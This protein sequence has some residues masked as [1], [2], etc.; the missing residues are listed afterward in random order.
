MKEK[1]TVV[2]WALRLST[3]FCLL[4]V[5]YYAPRIIN[6]LETSIV[7]DAAIKILKDDLDEVQA[8]GSI[9]MRIKVSKIEGDINGLKS[10]ITDIRSAQ[11]DTNSSL[12]GIEALVNSIKLDIS[13]MQQAKQQ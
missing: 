2:L 7:Q 5:S 12:R 11:A 9:A 4:I 6:A 13:K 3:T 1:H 8:E 10:Q